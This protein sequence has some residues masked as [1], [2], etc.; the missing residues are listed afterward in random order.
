MTGRSMPEPCPA[1]RTDELPIGELLVHRVE[2][3][4]QV[5]GLLMIGMELG[6]VRY[7]RELSRIAAEGFEPPTRGL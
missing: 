3:R 5:A 4:G 1:T 2:A 7:R 6:K